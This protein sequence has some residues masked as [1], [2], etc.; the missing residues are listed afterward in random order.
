MGHEAFS[1]AQDDALRH[2]GVHAESRRVRVDVVEGTAHVLV[3]G[4]GPDVLMVNGIG[5]PAAFWAP[6][7]AR[8]TGCTLHAVDMP[9]FGLTDSTE[10]FAAPGLRANA[11]RFLVEVADGLGLGRP[12]RIV[13]SS[14]GS[15]WATWLAIDEPAQVG[16]LVHVGCP[17]L[18]LGTSA[19]LPMRLLSVPGLGR[20][21]LR[22]QPPSTGQVERLA[23][24]VGEDLSRA[25]V[26]R[27]LLVEA[28]RLP[29]YGQMLRSLLHELVRVRGARP[30]VALL[31]DEL[32]LVR[33]PVQLVW[34]A[35]DPFGSL[36][37]AEAVRRA[38][39]AAGLHVV[40]GGHAPWLDSADA[41]AESAHTFLAAVA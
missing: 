18:V 23:G 21:L 22:M 4:T 40:P 6:L 28:E 17:A 8:L 31:A 34:G 37:V 26:L 33:Q 5:L 19:P 9:A 13:A 39:P 24:T 36:E 15:L 14:L 38:L 29:G 41:V 32:R 25:P 27:D 11:T 10:R 7:L 12:L 30:G 1:R 16:A 2:Y 3:T 35:H 20:A